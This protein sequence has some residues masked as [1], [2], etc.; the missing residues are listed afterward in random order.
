MGGLLNGLIPDPPGPPNPQ[1]WGPK[2]FGNELLPLLDQRAPV[3]NSSQTAAD[4][5]Q[6]FRERKYVSIRSYYVPLVAGYH[7]PQLP[8]QTGGSESP[9]YECQPC[10]WR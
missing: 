9:R 2:K 10:G 7:P 5:A 6:T 1:N 8:L 3:A 4:T